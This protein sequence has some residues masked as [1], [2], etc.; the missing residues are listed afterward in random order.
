MCVVC[1]CLLSLCV[2]VWKWWSCV[3]VDVIVSLSC[4]Q[5]LFSSV[6]KDCVVANVCLS[7]YIQV[8]ISYDIKLEAGVLLIAF[9][10]PEGWL[11][12]PP[13]FVYLHYDTMNLQPN[14][15]FVSCRQTLIHFYGLPHLQKRGGKSTTV[16][17]LPKW[18][19]S[20]SPSAAA[21]CDLQRAKTHHVF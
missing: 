9:S 8:T 19:S 14:A 2:C 12:D 4:S 11:S 15:G 16:F 1:S 3:C 20:K 7:V 10:V 18:H 21:P 13:G 6:Q 17:F 5:T